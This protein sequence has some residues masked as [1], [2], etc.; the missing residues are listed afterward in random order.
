MRAEESK[1]AYNKSLSKFVGD[2]D[3]SYIAV[4]QQS[5]LLFILSRCR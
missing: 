1:G 4:Q 2:I 5:K 3:F